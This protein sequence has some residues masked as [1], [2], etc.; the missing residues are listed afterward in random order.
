LDAPD[1]TGACVR[2]CLPLG[3]A[4]AQQ[5]SAPNLSS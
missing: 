1:G 4:S 3:G 2:L 5:G